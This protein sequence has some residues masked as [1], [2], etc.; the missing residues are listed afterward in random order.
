MRGT[1][2]NETIYGIAQNDAKL[3]TGTRDYLYGGGGA[4][5]FVLGDG[6]GL[7]YNDN[8]AGSAGR[9]D[10]AMIRDFDA[11]DRIQLSGTASDYLLHAETLSGFA[12]TS[13]FRDTN[14]SGRLDSLDEFVGHVSGSAAA[15]ALTK[16]YLQ[17]S[18]G[19]PAP[20]PTPSPTPSP[21]VYGTV[22]NDVLNGTASSEQIY[23]IA[24]VDAR[25]G[26]GTRDVVTGGGG[27]DVFV[28]G[29]ARG[30]FYD[31]GLAYS[32][33]RSDSLLIRDFAGDDR[34]QLSGQMTDYLLRPETLSGISGTSIFH[35]TNENGRWDS[36]DE[37][38][39]HVSGPSAP[40][41]LTPDYFTFV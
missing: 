18:G 32:A 20:A 24:S 10:W 27:A 26:S 30:L 23:G 19:A 6:R 1:S 12:G 36:L 13:I 9:S 5:V 35:D 22:G 31:D 37:F 15:L 40:A 39:A 25:L 7:F 11:N 34:I 33:G 2:A 8:V 29:D 16:S 3:G 38:V 41:Q 17:F 4:D 28:L 14:G 21:S